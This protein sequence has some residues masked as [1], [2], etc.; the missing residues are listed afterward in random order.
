MIEGDFKAEEFPSVAIHGGFS[1]EEVTFGHELRL[2]YDLV[3]C[4]QSVDSINPQ[5]QVTTL[6]ARDG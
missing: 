5:F 2:F 4:E 1:W 6:W 3:L